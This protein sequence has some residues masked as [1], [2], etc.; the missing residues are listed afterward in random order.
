MTDRLLIHIVDDDEWVRASLGF[1][2]D[3]AGYRVDHYADAAAF[4][5]RHQTE[6][7]VLICDV[8]MPGMSGIELTRLLAEAHSN[9]PTI[10]MTGHADRAMRA[11]ALAAGAAAV[12]EKPVALPV[13]LAEVERVTEGWI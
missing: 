6:H 2:L 3:V 4:L 10:L 13:L 5:A 12:L 1:A 8:R 11:E 9:I 7:G